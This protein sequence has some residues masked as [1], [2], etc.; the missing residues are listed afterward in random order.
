MHWVVASLNNSSKVIEFYDSM[1]GNSMEK[2]CGLLEILL[3]KLEIEPYD[4]ECIATPKQNNGY[5]CGLFAI[6]TMQC[7]AKNANFHFTNAD[8]KYYRKIMLVEIKEG[9]LFVDY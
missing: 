1:D 6:K 3:G 8:M 5:D 2:V 7:L 9:R 4:W